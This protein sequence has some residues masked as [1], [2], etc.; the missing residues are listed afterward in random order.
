MSATFPT[1]VLDLAHVE[2]L[3]R[4]ALGITQELHRTRAPIDPDRGPGRR[5]DPDRAAL[6][7][8]LLRAADLARLA[9]AELQEAYWN[10][11]G[12]DDPREA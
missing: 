4:S 12:Y 11:K 9:G 5:N 6:S 2:D 1:T 7:R 8:D 3:L 10:V